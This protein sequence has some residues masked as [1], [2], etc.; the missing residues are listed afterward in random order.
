[1]KIASLNGCLRR[2]IGFTLIELLVVIAIIAI[3]AS[4]LLPALSKAKSKG[5]QTKCLNNLKQLGLGM[6]M[7]L[8]DNRDEFP[9]TASRN[10]YGY[11]VEDWIYWRTNTKVYPPVERSLIA[12]SLG[13]VSSNLFRCPA[14]MDDS[15]RKAISDGNGPYFFSYSLLSHDLNGTKNLGMASIFDGQPPNTKG[16]LFKSTAI[17]QPSYKIMF[18]EEQATHKKGESPDVGGTSSIINDGR[19]DPPGDY[20]TVRHN[21]RGN[22]AMPDG[23]AE[24]IT[25]KEAGL[26][27]RN[28]P[29]T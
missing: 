2:K 14:D 5:L 18:A 23:H 25:P 28:N 9:G 15:E 20:I 21:K 17:T 29:T 6:S 10:T 1:M 7:Y 8:N 11:H 12:G 13:S 19:W 16:Y 4:M 24:N 27:A 3:L 22:V 26:D